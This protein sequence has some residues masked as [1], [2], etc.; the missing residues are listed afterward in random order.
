MQAG[1]RYNFSKFQNEVGSHSFLVF[2]LGCPYPVSQINNIGLTSTDTSIDA[3]S[4][5]RRRHQNGCRQSSQLRLHRRSDSSKRK[6]GRSN[7]ATDANTVSSCLNEMATTTDANSIKSLAST[8]FKTESDEDSQ[9]SVLV[10]AADQ[11]E[12]YRIVRS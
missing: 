11:L 2:C 9:R 3:T 10:A 5:R 12:V 8:A 6:D 1:S 7:F 4:D